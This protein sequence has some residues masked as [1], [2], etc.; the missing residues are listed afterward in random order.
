LSEIFL[1]RIIIQEDI[2]VNLLRASCKMPVIFSKLNQTQ[3]FV[4]DFGVSDFIKIRPV[5]AE[6]ADGEVSNKRTKIRRAQRL[7][8]I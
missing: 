6:G 5:G 7:Y 4:T 2:V 8:F 3:I 1:I